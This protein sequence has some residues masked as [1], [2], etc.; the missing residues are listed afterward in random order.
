M[1]ADLCGKDSGLEFWGVRGEQ[2]VHI[3]FSGLILAWLCGREQD[4]LPSPQP[5]GE[6]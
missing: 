4:P 6:Y 5:E 1:M 3:L 2:V